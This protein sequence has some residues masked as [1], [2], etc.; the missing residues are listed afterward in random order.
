MT[1]IHIETQGC[2]ANAAESE[3]MAGLLKTAGFGLGEKNTADVVLINVCT[4]KGE[5]TALRAIK[6][7]KALHPSKK[8]VVAGCVTQRLLTKLREID[9][10]ACVLNTHNIH[11]IVSVVE[12]AVN[13]TPLTAFSRQPEVKVG[14]PR[15]QK[16]PVVG[17]IPIL[18]SCA[19]HCTFCSTKLVKGKL[20][21]YPKQA[22]LIETRRMLVNGCKELWITSQ[23]NGAYMLD[24]GARELPSLLLEICKLPGDFSVR[25]GMTNPAHIIK[26]LPELLD[27]Y[28]NP[29]MYQ[30]L[31]IPIQSGNNRILAL[32]QRENNVEEYESIITECKKAFPS[33][34]IATDAIVGFPTETEAEFLDTVELLRKTSPDIVNISRFR[35]RH[36]TLAARMEQLPGEETK[37]R[38]RLVSSICNN[39][40]LLCNEKWLGWEGKILITEV[41]KEGTWI[42]RNFAY[43]Q[44][45]VAGNYTLGEQIKVKITKI[46]PYDLHGILG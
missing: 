16:N 20:L 7:T 12:E 38:S 15:V 11:N 1:K 40:S 27:V 18:N 41:G 28:R 43:K 21:S 23:D 34:T 10:D 44:I 2:S 30:F 22:I 13:N 35:V 19:S 29:H 14:L 26:M 8:L 37:R 4:V 25:L 46:T 9:E 45:I 33:M 3:I 6:E 17:I 31:H 32:M 39:I 36:G 5:S 42:G 24:K